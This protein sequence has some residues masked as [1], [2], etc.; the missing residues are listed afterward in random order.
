[1][2]IHH[3]PVRAA[4]MAVAVVACV[5]ITT[6]LVKTASAGTT[7]AAPTQTLSWQPCL[8]DAPAECASLPVPI[9]WS[10]PAA[11]RIDVAVARR[12]ATDAS[13]RIGTLVILPGG[14]GNSGVDNLITGNP[15]PPDVAARFD[16]VSF[17]PRGTN[18]SHPVVCDAD[19]ARSLPNVIVDTGATLAEVR[20]YGKRLSDSCRARTGPLIDH[21][22]SVSTARDIDALRV[23]IGADKISLTGQSYG[24][25][26]GQMYAETF[27]A[28]VRA[29]LLDSVFDHS[30]DVGR[31]AQTSAATAEDSFDEF[32]KWC[33]ADG[34]CAL[35]GRDAGAVFD[36]LYAEAVAGH[37]R[38]PG[39]PTA[40]VSPTDLIVQA[41][42]ALYEPSWSEL[43]GL[44][45]ALTDQAPNA[46]AKPAVRSAVDVSTVLPLL[47]ADHRVDISGEREWRALWQR[48]NRAAPHLRLNPTWPEMAIC[49]GWTA[50]TANPQH[51]LHIRVGSPILLMN[52]LHDPATGYAWATNVTRQIGRTAVLLTY[53]GWGH[54]IGARTD[55]TR[56]AAKQYLLDLT[57]PAPNTH[58]PAVA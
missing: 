7:P 14:P 45:E 39:D 30:L 44:L 3:R 35:H 41:T 13:R 16:V 51:D 8:P 37:L 49:S 33:A 43:A 29:L 17:D 50:K 40:P 4:L 58:C 15:L 6:T 26:T 46:T 54:A 23:A 12:K 2:P 34:G 53:D 47:C 19:L 10:H 9:D 25:L 36:D 48:Q 55:C 1:M 24:T 22:D 56:Q 21:L 42:M 18:R 11:G 38:L 52:S 27:P 28:H 20:D 32:A 31:F 5:G 57:V